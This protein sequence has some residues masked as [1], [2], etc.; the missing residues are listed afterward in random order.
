MANPYRGEVEIKLN[1]LT[2]VMRLTLGSLA[3]LEADLREE[4][5]LD[6]VERFESGRFKTKDIILLLNA[7]LKGAGWEGDAEALCKAEIEG[8]PLKAV[9]LAGQLLKLAFGDT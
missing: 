4:S 6:L 2:H 7:G 3:E 1:G 5:L 9:T 8:G